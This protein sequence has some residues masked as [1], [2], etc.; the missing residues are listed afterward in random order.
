MVD[1]QE[2]EEGRRWDTGRGVDGGGEVQQGVQQVP[3]SF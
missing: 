2:K 3:Y 1:W